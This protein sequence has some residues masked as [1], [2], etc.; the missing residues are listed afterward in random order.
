MTSML[1]TMLTCRWAARRIQRYLDADPAAALTP[2]EINRLR[3]HLAACQKCATAVAYNHGIRRVLATWGT[4]SAP[5]A[6]RIA[7]VRSF[8][9]T[10]THEDA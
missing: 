6:A 8:A 3:T 2:E 1:A 10:L 9:R 5:D 7:R 4:R